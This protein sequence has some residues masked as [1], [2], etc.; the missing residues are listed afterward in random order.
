[1]SKE[2]KHAL[3]DIYN[4]FQWG[5]LHYFVFEYRENVVDF[6][7]DRKY[8]TDASKYGICGTSN[9]GARPQT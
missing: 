4:A 1:M 9:D 6:R 8:G 2:M 5:Y 3:V 7:H